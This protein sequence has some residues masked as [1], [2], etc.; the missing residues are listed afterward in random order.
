MMGLHFE[1]KEFIW[2]FTLLPVLL[3]LFLLL[4]QWK[5]RSVNRIGDKHLVKLLIEDYSQKLFNTKFIVTSVAFAAGILAVMNLR[6]PGK[7]SAENRVGIDVAITLDVSNSMLATDIAPSRLERA[8]QFITKLMDAMPDDRIALIV[9]AGKAYLQMPLT[10][11]HGAAALFVASAGPGIVT[12]QGTDIRDA[13]EM[14]AN[15]FSTIDEHYKTVIMIT[16][17]EDHNENAVATAKK[18]A[19]QGVMVNTVGIGSPEGATI[20]DPV[21]GLQKKDENGNTVISKLN[22][23]VLKQVAQAT[24]G[25][26]THLQSSDDAV[27]LI[28]SQVSQIEK[29]AFGDFSRMN[30]DTYYYL[31]AGIMFLLL[32]VELFIPEVKKIVT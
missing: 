10:N 14:S 1:H 9:F 22:E 7:Q 21:T 4:L 13:L 19:A 2:L 3:L 23:E 12:Q 26:Y 32:T 6:E 8:K 29:K 18:L 25:T 27:K 30:F 11:D 20:T 17:G 24:N 5:K 16:D 28:L 15:A 31:F